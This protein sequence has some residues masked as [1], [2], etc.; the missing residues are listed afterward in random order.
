[1]HLPL[2][3][4]LSYVVFDRAGASTASTS[5]EYFGVPVKM[6]SLRLQ[7]FAAKG[8]SCAACGLEAK[9]FKLAPAG[10]E[11]IHLNLYGEKDGQEILFTKDHIQPKSRGGKSNLDN[12]QTMCAPCNQFKGNFEIKGAFVRDEATKQ[13]WIAERRARKMV[14]RLI[15]KQ[16]MA[17]HKLRVRARLDPGLQDRLRIL[18]ARLRKLQDIQARLQ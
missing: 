4:V 5:K 1:M 3:A 2:E 14:R 9:Y 16:E 10:G 13:A 6:D 17:I 15:G 8:T 11:K 12:L 18:R 7:T